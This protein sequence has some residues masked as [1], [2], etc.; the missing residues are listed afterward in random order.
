LIRVLISGANGQVGADVARL[1]EGRA[2][3]LAPGRET[4]DLADAGTIVR[5][6]REARP[7]LI[8]NAGAYT[9]VDRA[10]AETD[11]ARVV[12]G[13]APGV[14]AEEARRLGA[15]LVHY[16]TDY[17]FDGAKQGAYVEDD[18]PAPLNVYGETKLEGERAVAQSGCTHLIVRTS[19]VYAP[20]GR[21][22]LLTMLRLARERAEIRVVDDQRGA[23]TTSLEIA[24]ATLALI[25]SNETGARSNVPLPLSSAG[26]ERA[27][28]HSGLYHATARG[29]TTWFG[30]AQAIFEERSR[31]SSGTFA[32][33][34]VVPI[35]TRDYPTPARRPLNSVLSCARLRD[36]FG[37][38]LADWRAALAEA[39]SQLPA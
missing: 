35:P 26:L 25:D 28:L 38:E 11:L 27:A 6:V 39:I 5:Y 32:V 36:V 3:L 8:V 24:R 4:L 9:A 2:E 21:N 34:R 12:N 13:K 30:F 29:E 22:F 10:E 1:L 7:R 18:T 17:V 15:L 19:W 20:R 14:L 16:S 23:P 33:P 31:R 37:I